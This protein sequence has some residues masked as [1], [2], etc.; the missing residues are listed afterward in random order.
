MAA[1]VL[2]WLPKAGLPA[3]PTAQLADALRTAVEPGA[4]DEDKCEWWVTQVSIECNN[5]FNE[6]A[7]EAFLMANAPKAYGVIRLAA[8]STTESMQA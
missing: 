6:P 3:R 1:G 8:I 2:R 7:L 5:L 4:F